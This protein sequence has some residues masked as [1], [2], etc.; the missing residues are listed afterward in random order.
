MNLRDKIKQELRTIPS[1]VMQGG[2]MTAMLWKAKAEKAN[3][4]VSQPRAT[5]DELH[6]ALE[7]LR[8]FK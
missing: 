1:A 3:K 8:S 5:D 4:L 7:D 2:V 6:R